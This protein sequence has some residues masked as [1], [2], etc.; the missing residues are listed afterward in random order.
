MHTILSCVMVPGSHAAQTDCVERCHPV[1]QAVQL[2]WV[3]DTSVPGGH[4]SQSDRNV[5]GTL[6][7]SHCVHCPPA[8]ENFP[9]SQS[10]Q[11]RPCWQSDNPWHY[12]SRSS[13]KSGL[14][15][16]PQW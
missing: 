13:S 10:G 12:C 14:Q 16:S 8:I 2:T 4:V 1:A 11:F 9:G 3:S 6:P 5:F 15:R 7:L